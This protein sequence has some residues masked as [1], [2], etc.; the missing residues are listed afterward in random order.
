MFHAARL[1]NFEEQRIQYSGIPKSNCQLIENNGD[2][3]NRI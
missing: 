1:T 3:R 2:I